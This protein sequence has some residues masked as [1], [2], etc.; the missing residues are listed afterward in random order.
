MPTRLT[1]PI[2]VDRTQ[3]G[4]ALVLTAVLG[5]LAMALFSMALRSGHDAIRG[6]AL[7][8]RRERRAE[9]ITL[10]LAQA[11]AVLRTGLPPTDPYEC[12][13]TQTD[14]DGNSYDCKLTF[15]LSGSLQYDLSAVLATPTEMSSLPT[16][17][18]SF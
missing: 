17:P 8:F 6:E 4:M 16:L 7:E 13:V 14:G 5:F 11:A 10:S 12:V 3:Q 9:S 15:S 2:V 18:A 1:R